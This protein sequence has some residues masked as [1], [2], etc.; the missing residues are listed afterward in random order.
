[1]R[2]LLG[3]CCQQSAP[4]RNQSFRLPCLK[5]PKSVFFQKREKKHTVWPSCHDMRVKFDTPVYCCFGG[6]VFSN[7]VQ[8]LGSK[9]YPPATFVLP[10]T[11]TS[12]RLSSEKILLECL[13]RSG[14][15]VCLGF[16]FC[17]VCDRICSAAIGANPLR[18]IREAI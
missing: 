16:P 3:Q 18:P 9:A 10:H 4:T 8:A 13:L 1:M 6:I 11:Q 2:T 17:L 15:C 12:H 5:T 7:L 14:N